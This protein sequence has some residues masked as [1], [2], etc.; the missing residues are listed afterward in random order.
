[1]GD[2][3]SGAQASGDT[4]SGGAP[5]SQAAAEALRL[6][7]AVQDWARRTSVGDLTAHL[8]EGMGE[9][10]FATGAPECRLCPVCQLVGLLRQTHPEVAEHLGDAMSSLAEAVRAAVGAHE[11]EWSSRRSP[12]VERIDIG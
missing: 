5:G 1:V 11:R 10:G 4:G 7:E 6:F 9:G 2:V 12:G 3:V 8:A